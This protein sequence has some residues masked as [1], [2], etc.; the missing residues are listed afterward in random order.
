MQSKLDLGDITKKLY[1]TD[2]AII[3]LII[4]ISLSPGSNAFGFE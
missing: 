2:I 3:L 4:N 1:T